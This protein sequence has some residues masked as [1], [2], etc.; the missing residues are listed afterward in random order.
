VVRLA[1]ALRR[2]ARISYLCLAR[3]ALMAGDPD[4]VEEAVQ[5]ADDGR[6]LLGEV[7]RVHGGDCCRPAS[8]VVNCAC[9]GRTSSRGLPAWSAFN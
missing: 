7:A 5:L 8:G 9:T 1:I 4:L 2:I 6:D 3:V